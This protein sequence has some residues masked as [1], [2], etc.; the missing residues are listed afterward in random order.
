MSKLKEGDKCDL[1]D[2]NYMKL[3]IKKILPKGSHG[4]KCVLAECLASTGTYPDDNT[5]FALIKTFR[6]VDLRAVK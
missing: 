4:R 3:M 1:K 2:N 6:L 5:K